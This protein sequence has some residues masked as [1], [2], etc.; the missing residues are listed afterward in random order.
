MA[1]LYLKN[2]S[3]ELSASLNQSPQ[4]RQL[5]QAPMISFLSHLGPSFSWNIPPAFVYNYEHMSADQCLGF[6][7]LTHRSLSFFTCPIS[8]LADFV[9]VPFCERLTWSEPEDPAEH[10]EPVIDGYVSFATRTMVVNHI[11]QVEKCSQV[12]DRAISEIIDSP[13]PREETRRMIE[14]QIIIC[15]LL[16]L[17]TIIRFWE[18][19]SL[20]FGFL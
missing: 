17:S 16:G 3:K 5:Q 10:P 13:H 7:I 12:I 19:H 11:F 14:E 18:S 9:G 8:D 4:L 15:F 1:A 2:S 20:Y 6:M